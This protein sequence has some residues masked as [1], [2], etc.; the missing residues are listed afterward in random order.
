MPLSDYSFFSFN[1]TINTKSTK[2]HP[3]DGL[4]LLVSNMDVLE[5]EFYQ[6][7]DGYR[8]ADGVKAEQAMMNAYQMERSLSR[9][10]WPLIGAIGV[11]IATT[12][13]VQT[14]K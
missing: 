5:D 12:L 13:F 2:Q 8:V 9:M 7:L 4:S 10:V 3:H 14:R 1:A 6:Q 11:T